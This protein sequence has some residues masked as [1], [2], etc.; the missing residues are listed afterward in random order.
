LTTPLRH[1]VSARND[2]RM[3]SDFFLNIFTEEL[4]NRTYD[5]KFLDFTPRFR[6]G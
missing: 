5:G 6:S 2:E 4:F 3:N 1:L